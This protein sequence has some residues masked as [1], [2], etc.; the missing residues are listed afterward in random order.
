MKLKFFSSKPK[1]VVPITGENHLNQLWE[2]DV[3]LVVDDSGS[4]GGSRWKEAKSALEMLATV[5]TQY[6]KDGIEIHFLNSDETMTTSD[7]KAVKALF[8]SVQ[9]KNL[10]P[11]GGRMTKLLNAYMERLK[12][13][14]ETRKVNFIVIT[15]GAATDNPMTYNI[16]V[17]TARTLDEMKSSPNQ[18]GIQFVQVGDD[19]NATAFLKA[20]D[21]D[22]KL[23][24]KVRVCRALLFTILVLLYLFGLVKDMVDTTSPDGKPLDLVKVLLGAINRRVDVKGSAVYNQ[25]RAA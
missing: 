17:E 20:L 8:N 3:V 22:L 2:F 16:I 4:M 14:P 24:A 5:A 7:P 6:D 23:H 19:R 25:S 15:D 9:P 12:S 11:L 18:I 13:D 10:T 1:S 21:D